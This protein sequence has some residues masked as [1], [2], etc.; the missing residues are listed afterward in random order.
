MTSAVIASE[1]KTWKVADPFPRR[2]PASVLRTFMVCAGLA[3]FAADL[4]SKLAAEDWPDTFRNT[5]TGSHLAWLFNGGSAVSATFAATIIV[6][7]LLAFWGWHQRTLPSFFAAGITLGGL[8]GNMGDRIFRDE[9]GVVDWL[10]IPL[11]G[12]YAA[13]MN[14]ADIC[15][16]SGLVAFLVCAVRKQGRKKREKLRLQDAG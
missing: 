15:V 2:Y 6:A 9:S 5:G 3:V 4:V 10:I 11:G 16:L 14:I 1:T 13:A 7:A 12:D 8:V